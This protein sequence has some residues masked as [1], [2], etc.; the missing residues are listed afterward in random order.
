ML[1]VF[2]S[3]GPAAFPN[4]IFFIALIISTRVTLCTGLNTTSALVI[5]CLSFSSFMIFSIH[6]FHILFS[7]C[8]KHLI[9]F[10]C[11]ECFFH[12]FTSFPSPFIVFR[13]LII[14]F[15][16]LEKASISFSASILRALATTFFV[17]LQMALY[18]V[19]FSSD[20]W[21]HSVL[22]ISFLF[23]IKFS[24]STTTFLLYFSVSAFC[25]ILHHMLSR[26]YPE[27]TFINLEFLYLC[28]KLLRTSLTLNF[29]TFL[30]TT[31]LCV[32]LLSNFFC[33]Y[34]ANILA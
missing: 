23:A 13:N 5:W 21:L 4:F 16:L 11:L 28:S 12:L 6:C 18:L 20:Q 29:H 9:L 30:F 14:L 1:S 10:Q 34:A 19:L 2:T 33:L 22:N 25:N 27:M 32:R 26:C 31:L 8:H 17:L 3:E 7:Q 15:G 24:I